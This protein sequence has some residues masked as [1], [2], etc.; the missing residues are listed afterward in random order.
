MAETHD[1]E[2][3]SMERIKRIVGILRLDGREVELHLHQYIEIAKIS[4]STQD[5][6]TVK[7]S[8]VLISLEDNID[9]VYISFIFSGV[10]LFGKCKFVEQSIPYIKL[11]YPDSLQSRIKRK[12]PRIKPR[13]PVIAKF[14][15]KRLPERR[16]GKISSKELPVKYSKLYWEAQ[17]ES[18]DI[19]KLF[20]L[21]GKEMKKISQYS[22]IILY[23]KDNMNTRDAHI[24]RKSGKVLYINDCSEKNAYTRFIPSDKIISYS[25][26]LDEGKIS[27]TSPQEL[28]NELN[29]IINEDKKE[30]YTSKVLIPIFSEDEVIGHIR[31]FQKD[32]NKFVKFEDV[33]DLMAL[34]LILKIGLEKSHLVPTLDDSIKSNLMN[35]SEGGL[36]LKISNKDGSTTIPE[37]ADTQIR[38]FIY[39]KEIALRGNVCRAD[40]EDSTYAIKFTDLKPDAKRALKDFV[41][42]HIENLEEKK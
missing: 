31:S 35:I 40:G 6:F 17:R 14:K 12:F 33:A 11:N 22:E 23:N 42:D 21:A 37:G 10:E 26:Y 15:Y 1:K 24:M 5:T 3:T 30:G 2:I 13:K 29:K 34:S 9:F 16:L 18:V 36:L 19:K 39:E 25:Y 28:Q 8:N 32:N 20:L 4:D 41:E 7:L 38:L 27:E